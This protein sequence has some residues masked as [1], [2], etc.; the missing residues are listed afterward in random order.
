[1]QGVLE[2]GHAL[3]LRYG[4][5]FGGLECSYCVFYNHVAPTGLL[6]S[7][8]GAECFFGYAT[9]IPFPL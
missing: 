3:S 9:K 2:T 8:V 1:M 4:S 7:P 5:P 6:E